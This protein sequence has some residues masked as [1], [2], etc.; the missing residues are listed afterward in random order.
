MKKG[1]GSMRREK[2]AFLARNRRGQPLAMPVLA[3][4]Q[5]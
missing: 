1:D 2:Q 5:R 4:A 3:L